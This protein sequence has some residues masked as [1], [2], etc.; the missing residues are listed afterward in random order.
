AIAAPSR[1]PHAGQ[2]GSDAI[3]ILVRNRLHH[4]TLHAPR[5]GDERHPELAR[6]D[7]GNRC[8][9]FPGRTEQGL[10]LHVSR[11]SEKS[12]AWVKL[13]AIPFNPES[14]EASRANAGKV[15]CLTLHARAV[16]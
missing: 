4:E 6:A 10:E 5:L 16:R 3:E 15:S 14:V 11:S 13:T 12:T 2:S 7:Q 8:G 9:V 1:N